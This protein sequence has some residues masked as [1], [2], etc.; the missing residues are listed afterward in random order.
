MS[1]TFA[2]DDVAPMGLATT[3]KSLQDCAARAPSTEILVVSHEAQLVDDDPDGRNRRQTNQLIA[4]VHRAF[5]EHRPLTLSPDH[6]WL[7]ER[8]FTLFSGMLGY[9]QLPEG[10]FRP[11][12][13]W[14]VAEPLARE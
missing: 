2:V 3:S 14:G 12:V 7:T 9:R 5:A 10:S 1:V 6:I 11:E 8:H 13:A 4:C